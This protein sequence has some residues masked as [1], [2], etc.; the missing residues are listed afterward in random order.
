MFS[1][2]LFVFM[3]KNVTGCTDLVCSLAVG[4]IA[5]SGSVVV[6]VQAQEV[7]LAHCSSSLPARDQEAL[8]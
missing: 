4:E 7:V 6:C 2:M 3:D 1:T 8:Q 5:A